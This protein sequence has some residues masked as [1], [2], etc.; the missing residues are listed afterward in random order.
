[1][2]IDLNNRIHK[3]AIECIRGYWGNGFTRQS[4]LGKDYI[5]VQ[6]V[7][8]QICKKTRSKDDGR[9]FL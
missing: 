5:V 8:N 9:Y 3:L 4:R 7:V 1:M 2:I 6:K